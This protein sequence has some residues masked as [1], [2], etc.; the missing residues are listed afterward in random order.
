M[1]VIDSLIFVSECVCVCMSEECIVCLH[2]CMVVLASLNFCFVYL[3]MHGSVRKSVCF[4]S[5]CVGV[6]SQSFSG[7]N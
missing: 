1:S 5:L 6:F 3:C 4:F 7:I 2:V